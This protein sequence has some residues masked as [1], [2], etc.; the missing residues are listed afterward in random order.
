MKRQQSKLQVPAQSCSQSDPEQPQVKENSRQIKYS[1]HN[2]ADQSRPHYPFSSAVHM[3]GSCKDA[4]HNKSRQT[5]TNTAEILCCRGC[6]QC[7][8][9]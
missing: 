5:D 4:S 9:S 8:F 6:Q 7:A 1:V 3:N 2:G